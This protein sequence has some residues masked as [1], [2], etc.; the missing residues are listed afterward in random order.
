M[1]NYGAPLN[2]H[3]NI[4][5][6]GED[7]GLSLDS[8][9]ASGLVEL[10]TESFPGYFDERDGRL[11]HSNSRSAYPLP[12]D[13]PEQERMNVMH[14]ILKRLIGACYVGPVPSILSQTNDESHKL[15]LDLCTGTGKWV[16]EMAR[17]FPSVLFRGIDIVPIA[18]R[19]P[20]PNVRFEIHDVNSGLRWG[21]GSIDVVHARSVSMAIR[22]YPTM[23]MEVAR[24]LRSGGLFVS[25]E[26]G[27]YP[28][29][30][31]SFGIDPQQVP[32]YT[33]A[34]SHF[35]DVVN[36]AVRERGIYPI[37]GDVPNMLAN[38]RLF[39]NVTTQFCYI[40]IGPWY[41]DVPMQR[42][43][44]AYRAAVMRYANSATPMLLDAGWSEQQ[45]ETIIDDLRAEL[46]TVRGLVGV[47]HIVY[48]HRL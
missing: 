48:A 31:P 25:V 29:F 39:R 7:D 24:V 44:H 27:R 3:P 19:Y 46:L 40:P 45:V 30:H 33:P 15:V 47:Y 8:P 20:L 17:L 36:D 10:T 12:A 41:P 42:V 9:D 6:G 26:W 21:D 37:A 38:T 13:T 18:T 28:Y 2:N 23:L 14:N 43:G 1:S 4:I 5:D 32:G 35:F 34:S 22:D 11:F 16:M